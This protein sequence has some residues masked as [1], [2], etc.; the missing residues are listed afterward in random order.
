MQTGTI[1]CRLMVLLRWNFARLHGVAE[2]DALTCPT[3]SGT[4][5]GSRHRLPPGWRPRTPAPARGIRCGTGE[6]MAAVRFWWHDPSRVCPGR[7]RASRRR[8]AG[9]RR[10][11]IPLPADLTG[12]HDGVPYRIVVPANWN[13]TLLLYAHGTRLRAVGGPVVPRGGA[14]ALPG[15]VPPRSKSSC[16]RMAT[17][18][19]APSTRT[20][21]RPA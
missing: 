5:R 16:W 14:D 21:S 19:P 1:T 20:T 13:G 9:P 4:A 15:A 6:T 11:H 18:L 10:A 2:R 8:R 7:P 12:T 17:P 3:G